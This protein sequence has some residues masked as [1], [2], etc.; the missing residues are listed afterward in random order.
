MAKFTRKPSDEVIDAEQF[1]H[2]ATSPRGVRTRENG[3]AYVVT[4]QGQEATLSPGD[5]VIEEPDRIHYY[6]CAPDVF[7]Q[8]YEPKDWRIGQ[9]CK[10]KYRTHPLF[11]CA[12]NCVIIGT[13]TSAI[14]K[15]GLLLIAVDDGRQLLQPAEDWITGGGTSAECAQNGH[16]L[17][18]FAHGAL[19]CKVC[20][21]RF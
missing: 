3:S 18:E 11:N 13:R 9:N 19:V 14:H 2:S 6:P 12:H 20:K 7:A 1:H 8:R 15:D 17:Q 16:V 21:Q 5:W 4:I 10:P